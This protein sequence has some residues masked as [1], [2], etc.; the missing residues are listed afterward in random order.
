VTLLDQNRRHLGV[1]RLPRNRK[2]SADSPTRLSH[3]GT[4]CS[5]ATYGRF[6][7]RIFRWS[8]TN[9]QFWRAMEEQGSLKSP[10]S[11]AHGAHTPPL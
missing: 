4:W 10:S 9:W 1:D 6:F 2:T 7:W 3:S 5:R 11:V 8:C